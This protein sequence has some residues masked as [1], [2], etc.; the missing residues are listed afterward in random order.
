MKFSLV[1]GRRQEAKPKLSGICPACGSVMTAKCGRVR[2]HHWAHKNQGQCDPW[3]EKESG[4]HRTWKDQFPS[5]WQ[6]FIQ[7][8][9]NGE[10]HIADVKTS[11]GWV[12]EFQHSALDLDERHSRENFYQKLIWVVDGTKRKS[13]IEPFKKGFIYGQSP[14]PLSP[15]K[16]RKFFPKG[17]LLKNW[18][19]CAGHVF[20][21]FG[22]EHPLWWV[23]P[24]SNE[25]YAYIQTISRDKFIQ[26]L[27]NPDAADSIDFD[28]LIG[29]FEAFIQRC[30]TDP[31]LPTI[32]RLKDI[33]KSTT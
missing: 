2:V 16:Y 23:Y 30:E 13:D 33:Q 21:D 12:I 18:S 31:E 4:W 9:G 8:D 1:N 15:N 11:T 7:R 25:T 32:K 5:E 20:F 19:E 22:E 27:Q 10:K 14:D 3:W 26:S 17:N 6:E 28:A 24:G 29:D